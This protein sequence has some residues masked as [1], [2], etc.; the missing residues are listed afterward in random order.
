MRKSDRRRRAAL[1]GAMLTLLAA[2]PV[3]AQ[4]GGGVD[5][6]LC[7]ALVRHRPAP[8]VEYTPGVDVRGRAVAPA[9]LPGSAGAGRQPLERF[10]IPVTPDF[11]RRMGL[12]GGRAGAAAPGNMEIGRLVIDGDRLT[13][14]G[15]TIGGGSEA[16]LLA[17]CGRYR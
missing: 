12:P 9:D 17:A 16:A 4:N 15:Q 7:Q 5:P 2:S 11:A 3:A 14:N 8:D 13:F 1:A 6:R 10:E